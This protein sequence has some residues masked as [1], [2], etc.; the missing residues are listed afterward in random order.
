MQSSAA[1]TRLIFAVLAF[2]SAASPLGGCTDLRVHEARDEADKIALAGGL[3]GRLVNTSRFQLVTYQRLARNRE[4]LVVYIEGDGL[5]W[6]N[7]GQA[8]DNPTPT[9]PL[10]L[11]LAAADDAPSVVYLARVCQFVTGV[12]AQ[13]CEPKYWTTA[14][15]STEVVEVADEAVSFFK[16]AVDATKVELIGYSGG[17]VLATLLAARRNDVAR[18]ITVAAN[19]DLSYWTAYHHVTP[20]S[21]S[22][23]PTDFIEQLAPIP[24]LIFVGGSDKI[25]PESITNRYRD[26]MPSGARVRIVSVVGFTHS[27]CW[28]EVWGSLLRTARLFR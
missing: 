3:S 28:A 6:I 13:N 20:L 26:A 11:R 7:R 18:V 23:K 25:V 4:A 15:F 2:G 12:A 21:Q 1:G 16:S 17:G 9:N 22:L 8:S 14:R 5:A 27:C 24:Q 10:G 19:L